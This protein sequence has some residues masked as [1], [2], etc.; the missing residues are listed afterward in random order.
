MDV[1]E[2]IRR[3]NRIHHTPILEDFFLLRIGDYRFQFKYGSHVCLSWNKQNTQDIILDAH[4]RRNSSKVY[5]STDAQYFWSRLDWIKTHSDGKDM[6]AFEWKDGKLHR[7]RFNNG[8][9][10]PVSN[11]FRIREL[12]NSSYEIEVLG[13]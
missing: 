9:I 6:I 4:T 2:F 1:E 13:R 3:I 7:W 12:L 11:G 5:S 8:H 10:I